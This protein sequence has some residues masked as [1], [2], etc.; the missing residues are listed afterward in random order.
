MV[1]RISKRIAKWHIDAA[2]MVMSVDLLQKQAGLR[3]P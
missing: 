1:R 2:C 3:N